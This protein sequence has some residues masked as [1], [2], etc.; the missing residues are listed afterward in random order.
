LEAEIFQIENW[1]VFL[2]ILARMAAMVG[3]LPIF[4]SSQAALRLRLG[5][6]AGLAFLLFPV[7][8]ISLSPVQTTPAGFILV[9]IQEA[10]LGL[11]LG[12]V[13]QLIFFAVQFGGTIVG[14]LMGFAAANILDPASFPV[15]ECFCNSSFSCP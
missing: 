2:V 9:I 12:F 5:L 13:T 15:S 7:T 10:V 14:Y 1:Y 8:D 4:T 6:A 3:S 11:L